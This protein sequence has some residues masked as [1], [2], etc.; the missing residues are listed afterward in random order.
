M[1]GFC[2][3]EASTGSSWGLGTVLTTGAVLTVCNHTNAMTSPK[4]GK[5]L[6]SFDGNMYKYTE[7]FY[8]FVILI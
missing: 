6:H 2:F 1:L 8:T 4:Q 7:Q 5:C 3:L